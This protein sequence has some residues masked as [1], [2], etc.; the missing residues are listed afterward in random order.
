MD[1][2]FTYTV[3]LS[4]YVIYIEYLFTQK[5]KNKNKII[6]IIHFYSFFQARNRDLVIGIL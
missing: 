2:Y 4:P 3:F 5:L 6:I 1:L